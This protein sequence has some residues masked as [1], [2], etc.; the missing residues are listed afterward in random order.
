DL[1][2]DLPTD[3]VKNVEDLGTYRVLPP[4]ANRRVYFLAVNS[5]IFNL[6]NTDLRKAIAHSIHRDKILD[7]VFRGELGKDVHKPLTGPYPAGSWAVDPNLAYK[8][9]LAKNR[10]KAAEQAG[11][12]GVTLSL[13]YPAGDARVAKAMEKVAEQVKAEVGLTVTPQ[14]VDPHQL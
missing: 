13:K 12:K 6:Q 4:L 14:A 2:P 3:L 9:E 5:R 7:D 8:P 1:V 10:M 11:I